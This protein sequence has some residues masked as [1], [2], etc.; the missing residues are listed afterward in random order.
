M[1]HEL[2]RDADSQLSRLTSPRWPGGARVQHANKATRPVDSRGFPIATAKNGVALSGEGWARNNAAA[3]MA[4][5]RVE[6]A[7]SVE[8]RRA[9]AASSV[10]ARTSTMNDEQMASMASTISESDIFR[11]PEKWIGGARPYDPPTVRDDIVPLFFE[12]VKKSVKPGLGSE[13]RTSPRWDGG[14]RIDRDRGS[15]ELMPEFTDTRL[16]EPGMLSSR[17]TSPRWDGGNRLD[18]SRGPPPGDTLEN[19]TVANCMVSVAYVPSPEKP[20]KP[21]AVL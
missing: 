20:S 21:A 12:S 10:A 14:N 6:V 16:T 2:E 8:E 5:N 11:G 4:R 1:N 3:V 17:R 13:R 7:A 18:R 19:P 9:L 15:T